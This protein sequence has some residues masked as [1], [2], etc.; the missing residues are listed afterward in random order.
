MDQIK[1]IQYFETILDVGCELFD[2][3]ETALKDWK[4]LQPKL[5]ELGDYYESDD[6]REDFED[7]EEGRLPEGVK[8][9]VLSED[10]IY[11]L[12]ITNDVMLKQFGMKNDT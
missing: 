10:A 5:Q 2:R 4:D 8:R 1:R 7:D 6:W 9:G 12:L 3:L 11:N